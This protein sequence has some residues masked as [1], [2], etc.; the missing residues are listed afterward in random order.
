L[1]G[2]SQNH[3]GYFT[4]LYMEADLDKRGIMKKYFSPVIFCGLEGRFLLGQGAPMPLT[5]PKKMGGLQ[6]GL[7]LRRPRLDKRAMTRT[8]RRH[9]QQNTGGGIC[10][11]RA[12]EKN[13]P[14]GFSGQAK[15]S[16]MSI[17]AWSVEHNKESAMPQPQPP[18]FFP[19]GDFSEQGRSGFPG[20]K[21]ALL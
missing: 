7:D 6:A 2:I 8:P 17:Q 15:K 3:L 18:S 21:V 14:P 12:Y 11:A 4:Q 13:G 16:V 9:F 1:W 20:D 5:A 10:P 19:L